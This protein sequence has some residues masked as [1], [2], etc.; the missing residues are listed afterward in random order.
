MLGCSVRI[1]KPMLF[2]AHRVVGPLEKEVE[3]LAV[4]GDIRA[5]LETGI[6]G[7]IPDGLPLG[8]LLRGRSSHCA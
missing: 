6:P 7:G 5:E 1:N 8:L 4:I 3:S 2:V